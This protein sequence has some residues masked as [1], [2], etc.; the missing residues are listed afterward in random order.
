MVGVL[1][2]KERVWTLNEL[3]EWLLSSYMFSASSTLDPKLLKPNITIIP[4]LRLERRQSIFGPK[5]MD[6]TRHS[7]SSMQTDLDTQ[8]AGQGCTLSWSESALTGHFE[9]LFK[10]ICH[11]TCWNSIAA[12]QQTHHE[13]WHTLDG[14]LLNQFLRC[15]K[16]LSTV[17]IGIHWFRIS[18]INLWYNLCV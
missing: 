7:S 8:S 17:R 15:M 6:T 11:L 9:L 1:K 12:P 2:Q 14:R 10:N 3:F 5:L 16:P 13:E 4:A 18:S